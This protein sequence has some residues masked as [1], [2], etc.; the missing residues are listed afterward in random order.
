MTINRNNY[1]EF[2]LLYVDNEL[3]AA[4]RV[5]VEAFVHENPDLEKELHMLQQSVI[6]PEKN[7]LFE[8][9]D[10]LMSKA[11]GNCP[12]NNTNYEEFFLLYVDGELNAEDGKAVEAFASLHPHLMEELMLLQQARLD[13]ADTISFEDKS[14]LYRHE[15]DKKIFWLPRVSV[16]A[17]LLLLLGGYLVFRD[18]AVHTSPDAG[19]KDYAKKEQPAVTP[20]PVD[21]LYQKPELKKQE[22]EATALKLTPKYNRKTNGDKKA[23]VKSAPEKRPDNRLPAPR[24][25]EPN[26]STNDLAL[27]PVAPVPVIKKDEPV[28]DVAAGKPEENPFI[29]DAALKEQ[30]AD[31]DN[32]I[33]IAAFSSSRKNKMRGL[34]RKV[35]RVFEKSSNRDDGG[36]QRD[37]L[38]GNFQIALK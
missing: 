20:A 33:N 14:S 4:G 36:N 32:E 16:A 29:T 26:V 3:S 28:Q 15:R 10:M 1:E 25:P 11:G 38:I 5:S 21:P 22:K 31:A 34:F 17:A 2:F 37:V 18:T 7:I 23:L 19:P 13:P 9:K 12:I 27:K 6:K 35:S 30:P 8:H 24:L